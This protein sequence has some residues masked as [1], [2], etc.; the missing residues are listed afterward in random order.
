MLGTVGTK[1]PVNR[2]NATLHGGRRVDFSLTRTQL[3]ILIIIPLVF[4]AFTDNILASLD[5]IT[6]FIGVGW[7]SY[8]IG[9]ASTYIIGAALFTVLQLSI[10]TMLYSTKFWLGYEFGIIAGF[11]ALVSQGIVQILLIV[12]G[13]M[14]A[15]NAL[16]I[17]D[18]FIGLAVINSAA[19]T[20]K[21][22]MGKELYFLMNAGSVDVAFISCVA[23]FVISE[24]RRLFSPKLN[25]PLIGLFLAPLLLTK[26]S[27]GILG[28]GLLS[29]FYFK[30]WGLAVSGVAALVGYALQGQFLINSSG[31][32]H[33]WETSMRF[34]W[35]SVDIVR[36]AGLGSFKMHGPGLQMAEAV[37][38][39]SERFPAFLTMHN[40][41]LQILFEL[42]LLG[43]V[44]VGLV[45]AE[46][47]YKARKKFEVRSSLIMFGVM[48]FIQMPLR[49]ALFAS[50][51][52][53]LIRAAVSPSEE[54]IGPNSNEAHIQ[55]PEQENLHS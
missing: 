55:S 49:I 53:F 39:N 45:Y 35:Q 2:Q 18:I 25:I 32:F 8:L 22:F 36:G 3:I 47:L 34:F 7:I 46:A 42:G 23:P 16:L 31:R 48:A 52:A 43:F 6:L 9:K 28:L 50:F 14:L 4:C 17:L 21:F 38:N 26:S 44:G 29:I 41:W 24:I 19:L 20:I 27:S 10:T 13:M 30:Y 33:V 37:L 11:E 12:V 5:L 51:G 40:D 1:A 54:E 15:G